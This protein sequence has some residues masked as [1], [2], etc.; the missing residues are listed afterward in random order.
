MEG[1][2]RNTPIPRGMHRRAF[3]LWFALRGVL[4]AW[5]LGMGGAWADVQ[6]DTATGESH[7]ELRLGVFAFR[8]KPVI[9]ERFAELGR[10]LSE[11]VNGHHVRVLALTDAELEEGIASGT[12]DFVLTNPSHYVSLREYGRLSGALASMVL[13]DGNTPVHSIGGVIVRRPERIDISRLEDLRGKR[14]SIAGKQYLGTYMAPA[15]ELVRAGVDLGAITF[16]EAS[17][18]VDRVISAVLE[19]GVDA[20]F[21]RT[22]VLEELERK[23]AS[24]EVRGLPDRLNHGCPL[25]LVGSFGELLR[26]HGTILRSSQWRSARGSRAQRP[27]ELRRSA[28]CDLSQI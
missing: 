24:M 25:P 20:G 19:G 9:E 1:V 28:E 6:T 23:L 12:L 5:L 15:A 21:V 27:L 13:R 11:H 16:V 17:Q 26:Q 14:V 18:P 2:V 10:Y 4:S 22:G 7:K 8:P 3:F